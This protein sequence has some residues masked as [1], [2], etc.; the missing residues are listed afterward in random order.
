MTTPRERIQELLDA[1]ITISFTAGDKVPDQLLVGESINGDSNNKVI[2]TPYNTPIELFVKYTPR[3]EDR[4]SKKEPSPEQTVTYLP[5]DQ[6]GYATVIISDEG[7]A[8][9]YHIYQR[10]PAALPLLRTRGFL[11]GQELFE[12]LRTHRQNP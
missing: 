1:D 12:L 9:R 7:T 4:F 10:Q 5:A 11:R 2:I 8:T 6:C 3:K